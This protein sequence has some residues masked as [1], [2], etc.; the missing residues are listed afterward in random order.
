MRNGGEA[1]GKSVTDVDAVTISGG[2]TCCF[3]FRL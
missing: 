3:I 1:A 2:G